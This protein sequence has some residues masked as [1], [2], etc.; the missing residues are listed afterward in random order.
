MVDGKLAILD[1][2]IEGDRRLPADFRTARL[3]R[4]IANTVIPMVKI[5]ED[6]PTNH[7][8]GKVPILDLEVWVRG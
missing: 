8:S 2:E 6:V 7:P 1:E 4:E 5:K 3:L